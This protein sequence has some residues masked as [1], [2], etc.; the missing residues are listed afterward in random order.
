MPSQELDLTGF[1]QG[2]QRHLIFVLIKLSTNYKE[3]PVPKDR[4]EFYP[5]FNLVL[6]EEPEAFL[7][8]SQQEALNQSLKEISAEA[9]E[10]V[11]ISTHSSHFVSKNAD[12]IP[13]IIK[14]RKEGPKTNIH[15]LSR[16]GL[17]DLLKENEELKLILGKQPKGKELDIESFWYSLW[18]DPDRCCSFFAD[19][20][21][22]CEGASEKVLLDLLIKEGKIQL[23]GKRLYIL[24]SAGK[25]NIH[26][27]MN[28]FCKLG[29]R[30]S[31]L[32]DG[33][34]DSERHQ[35]IN[36]FIHKSKNEFTNKIHQF[37]SDFEDFLK[38]DAAEDGRN[39]PLNVLWHYRNARISQDR[40]DALAEIVTGIV[41]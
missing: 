6:F 1:G 31:V 19:L 7:H 27:Y 22:I 14:L 35:K 38:I 26:R 4:K 12:D 10:Q 41:C 23:A 20:A 3:A 29:I 21:L 34:N 28:L 37:S 16:P 8:P 30:H 13:T 33:D 5:E 17:D 18:L 2:L 11:L 9:T 15:Q 25:E 40:I 36:E 32:F 24:H 39:K